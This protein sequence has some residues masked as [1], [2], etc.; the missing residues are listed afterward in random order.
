MTKMKLFSILAL[1]AMLFGACNKLD[2]TAYSNITPG[3]FFTTKNDVS[4]ALVA[5]YRPLQNCCGGPEQ[6]G[7]FVLNM[8]SDEG[9]SNNSLWS[10]YDNLTYTP[11]SASEVHDLWT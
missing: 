2:E 9:T 11:G 10:Q 3:N 7:L 1:A 8:V 4:A 6:A 5:A